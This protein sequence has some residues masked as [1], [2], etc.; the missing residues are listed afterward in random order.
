MRKKDVTYTELTKMKTP[1]ELVQMAG[2]DDEY[3]SLPALPPVG[4]NGLRQCQ[5]D[6]IKNLELSFKYGKKKA[7]VSLATGA[8]KTFTACTFTYRFLSYTS[9]RRVLFLVD[10]NNLGKQAEGEFTTYKLT[11]NGE[12]FNSIYSVQRLKSIEEIKNAQVVISTIQRLYSAITGQKLTEEND[13]DEA[14]YADG[15][16]DAKTEEEVV[17][18]G[19]L[20]LDEDFFD[21]IIVDECHRSIYGK[22]KQVLNHF[23]TAKIIGLTATPTPEAK[24]FFNDNFVA[25]YTFEDSVR[26]GVNVPP[27]VYRI[28]TRVSENGGTISENEEVFRISRFTG[29]REVVANTNEQQ[30][31]VFLH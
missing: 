3:A 17:L 9:V 30:Y 10:R 23:K 18:E 29:R 7:L 25:N 14:D 21:L 31:S 27:R 13:D 2:V 22:W 6:A 24:A 16:Y 1:K 8:G 20:L 19:K 4:E 12:V 11:E 28:K 5:F 26:D 15:F